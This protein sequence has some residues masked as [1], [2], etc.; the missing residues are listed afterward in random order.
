MATDIDCAHRLGEIKDGKQTILM[1][2]FARDV[3]D[4]LLRNKT[5]LKDTNIMLFED[6]SYKDR[7]LL[8]ALKARTLEVESAWYLAGKIWAKLRTGRKIQVNINDNLD[9]VLKGKGRPKQRR[10]KQVYKQPTVPSATTSP[11]QIVENDHPQSNGAIPKTTQAMNS[12]TGE[13][14]TPPQQGR[15][16]PTIIIRDRL[17]EPR[18]EIKPPPQIRH[19]AT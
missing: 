9:D 16:S 2:F 17:S 7:M 18:R 1:R 19:P 13:K 10:K 15:N 8:H 4:Y 6:M 3:V 14:S 12:I 11:K 5:R